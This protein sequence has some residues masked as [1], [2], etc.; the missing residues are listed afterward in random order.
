MGTY[1][2]TR[3]S[4]AARCNIRLLIRRHC[5]S[6]VRSRRNQAFAGRA[7]AARQI[8]GSSPASH[9]SL[10]LASITALGTTRNFNPVMRDAREA[11]AR[12]AERILRRPGDE[13]S[14]RLSLSASGGIIQLYLVKETKN[15]GR[16]TRCGTSSRRRYGNGRFRKMDPVPDPPGGRGVFAEAAICPV[17]LARGKKKSGRPY[18]RS[19]QPATACTR[20]ERP[21]CSRLFY[22]PPRR[23]R[24]RTGGNGTRNGTRFAVVAIERFNRSLILLRTVETWGGRGSRSYV[25]R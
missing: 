23:F 4:L 3:N 9:P 14:R 17:P 7:G 24:R 13:R 2:A 6:S 11:P 19:Y 16:T 15:G 10:P 18:T 5:D 25:L 22:C 12:G 1:T 21:I 8:V 20:P